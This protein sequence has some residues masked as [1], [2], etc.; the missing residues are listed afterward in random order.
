M[1]PVGFLNAFNLLAVYGQMYGQYIA[2]SY[3]M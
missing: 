2:D 1:Y 3:S